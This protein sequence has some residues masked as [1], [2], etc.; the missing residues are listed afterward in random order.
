MK[1]V[2]VKVICDICQGEGLCT[3]FCETCNWD[4]CESCLSNESETL[5]DAIEKAN[6]TSG[7]LSE[8]TF[9]VAK[10]REDRVGADVQ[11][12]GVRGHL[13]SA[14]SGMRREVC[15]K[16]LSKERENGRGKR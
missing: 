9:S 4:I 3:L 8:E 10:Q 6:K 5:G 2:Q 7:R 11:S 13:G 15:R 12:A 14:G 16:R 1:K